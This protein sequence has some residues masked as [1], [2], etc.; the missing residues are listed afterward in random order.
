MFWM[1][2]SHADTVHV[3]LCLLC[4]SHTPPTAGRASE[5]DPRKRQQWLTSEQYMCGGRA[6]APLLCCSSCQLPPACPAL[7]PLIA[8]RVKKKGNNHIPMNI[9][10]RLQQPDFYGYLLEKKLASKDQKLWQMPC[11]WVTTRP[12]HA[13]AFV[14]Y[15]HCRHGANIF[16]K[17]NHK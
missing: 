8:A 16:R 14:N 6:A 15:F 5:P 7:A 3:K 13:F 17:K 9:L 11:Y 2:H 1:G 12:M 10:L 4:A